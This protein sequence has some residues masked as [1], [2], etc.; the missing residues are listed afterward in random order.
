MCSRIACST[1]SGLPLRSASIR[2][3]W[4]C[5]SSSRL[6][7]LSA[8]VTNVQLD[9]LIICHSRSRLRLPVMALCGIDHGVEG[10]LKL[11]E[12]L[13]GDACGREPSRCAF[14]RRPHR[15]HGQHF[16]E[17][18]MAD[19]CTPKRLGLDEAHQFQVAQCFA[20]RGLA[21]AQHLSDARLDDA[22]AR[23]EL[24][25]QD[26]IDQ[27]IADFVAQNLSFERFAWFQ[28]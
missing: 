22:L 8:A 11:F 19:R 28:E 14:E 26:G 17:R 18:W 2:L 24:A 4:R 12:M 9:S 5:A 25:T 20:Y 27:V 6:W 10:R 3:W 15:V 16:F 7:P 21:D 13:I 23:L 1:A